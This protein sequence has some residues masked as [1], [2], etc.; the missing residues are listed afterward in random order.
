[1]KVIF[2]ESLFG[3]IKILVIGNHKETKESNKN[4]KKKTKG[5]S[6][7]RNQSSLP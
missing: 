6:L 4:V 1:M 7:I 2:Q 3:I 5:L